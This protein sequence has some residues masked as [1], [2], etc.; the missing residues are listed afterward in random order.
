MSVEFLITQ[1]IRLPLMLP[2]WWSLS[3]C[4]WAPC[5]CDLS[6]CA[7]CR[8]SGCSCWGDGRFLIP[9]TAGEDRVFML[10]L[11]AAVVGRSSPITYKRAIDERG[12][13]RGFHNKLK[14]RRY[15][16]QTQLW[17]HILVGTRIKVESMMY[18]LLGICFR[19]RKGEY[20]FT[21]IL[22]LHQF[23]I[24]WGLNKI[25]NSNTKKGLRTNQS[26]R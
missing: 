15:F 23:N 2:L 3:C 20:F 8:G 12:G 18:N 26:K 21:V 24:M 1:H 14:V 4:D 5:C 17:K 9:L 13:K 6:P 7:P 19:W 16:S 10:P 11:T 25:N 22:T